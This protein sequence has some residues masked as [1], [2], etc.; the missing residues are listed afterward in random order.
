M[1]QYDL[2][3]DPSSRAWLEDHLPNLSGKTAMVTGSTQGIGYAI[4][5]LI[6]RAG[7][8]VIFA[9]RN[10]TMA[11]RIIAYFNQNF[12]DNNHGV[13]HLDLGVLQ[14][15]KDAADSLIKGVNHL[16][17]IFANAGVVGLPTDC[18]ETG[19]NRTFFINHIGHFSFLGHLMPLIAR[20]KGIK[21]VLQSSLRH[22]SAQ[23]D[24]TF[25]KYFQKQV[26]IPNTVY[27]DSKLANILFA[28]KW[29]SLCKEQD[30][31][32]EMFSA[33]PGYVLT[34]INQGTHDASM[35][36]ILGSIS[37]CEFGSACLKLMHRFGF[38]Q[39]GIIAGSLPSLRAVLDEGAG[40]YSGPSGFLEVYGLPKDAA[41]SRRCYDTK[42]QDQLW[43]Q[44]EA[45]CRVNYFS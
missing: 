20:S 1:R 22:W 35:R 39:P 40:F 14:T 38:S 32:V 5:Y 16:D 36:S 29:S 37:A 27:A 23:K 24:L 19:H 7:G 9:V 28:M 10:V 15:T 18:T 6:A 25:E 12:G 33:H 31:D 11:E 2:V 13:A 21:I 4:A 34:S 42:L 41:M 30:L 45:F 26:V 3:I 43:E 44:S 17:Y 8:R